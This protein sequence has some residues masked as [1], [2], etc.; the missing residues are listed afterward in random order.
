MDQFVPCYQQSVLPVPEVFS[1]LIPTP[2]PLPREVGKHS[3]FIYENILCAILLCMVSRSKA[4][5]KNDHKRPRDTLQHLNYSN[6][7]P[8]TYSGEAASI[9]KE[10]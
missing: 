1:P 6:P 5:R 7:L 4:M 3:E 10:E 9:M 8:K 2:V